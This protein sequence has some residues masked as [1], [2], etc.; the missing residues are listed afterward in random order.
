MCAGGVCSEGGVYAGGGVNAGGVCVGGGVCSAG[1]VDL[2]LL[3][4]G[5]E[6]EGGGELAGED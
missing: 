1:G 6:G 3:G 4:R 2:G 5:L